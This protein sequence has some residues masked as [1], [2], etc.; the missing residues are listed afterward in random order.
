M[1]IDRGARNLERNRRQS[2]QNAEG[3]GV[4]FGNGLTFD[5]DTGTVGLNLDLDPALEFTDEALSVQLRAD[6]GLDKDT[7][8]LGIK[9][10]TNPGLVLS[11]DGLEVRLDGG[12]LTKGASGLS[13]T[14]PEGGW[15]VTA[16]QTGAYTAAAGQ[17]VRCDPS[18]GAFTVTLPTAVGISGRQIGI[19]NTTSDATTIT[20]DADGSETIDGAASVDMSAGLASLTFASDGAGWMVV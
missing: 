16:V 17:L 20:I 10:D 2:Q 11:A 3:L 9:L 8:G 14:A 6:G 12:T 15:T 18:G 1:A 4:T 7:D 13:V 19:K 5:P